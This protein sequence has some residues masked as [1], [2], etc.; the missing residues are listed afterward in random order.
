MKKIILSAA[1]AAAVLS[2][3]ITSA[4]AGGCNVP[5]VVTCVY[6]VRT[7]QIS[8]CHYQQTAYDHCG[9]AYCYTVAVYTFQDVYSNGTTRT[10]TKTVLV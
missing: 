9:R 7:V 6:K 5:P 1:I 8:C 4:E 10:W 3:G 2:A